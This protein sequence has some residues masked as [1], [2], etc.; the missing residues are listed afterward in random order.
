VPSSDDDN[1]PGDLGESSDDGFVQKF[2]NC[3]G[4][5]RRVQKP[6]PMIWY[7]EARENPHEQIS[8]KVCFTDVYQFRDSLR[9]FHVAQLRN[10]HYHKNNNLRIIVDY[11]DLEDR[12]PFYMTASIIAHE[13]TFLIIT[14]RKEHTCLAHGEN[15]K[16]AI[17]WLAQ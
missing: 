5:K 2:E 14:L 11:L 17:N 10:L 12:C 9:T 6:K 3:S 1:S 16:V 4:S 7:D 13:K 15:T 8:K